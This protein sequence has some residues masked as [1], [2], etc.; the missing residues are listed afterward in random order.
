MD[1]KLN[2]F[3]TQ[4]GKLGRPFKLIAIEKNLTLPSKFIQRVECWTWF[5]T[6]K[7]EDDKS[8]KFKVHED[9]NGKLTIIRN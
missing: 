6:F 2:T 3:E 5:Y 8:G 4:Y 9:Y 7:Y 1:I